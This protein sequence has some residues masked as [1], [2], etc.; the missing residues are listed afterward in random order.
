MA[1]PTTV[2]ALR[3]RDTALALI[4]RPGG[5]AT[6][7]RDIAAAAEVSPALL[8]RHYGS[9]DGVR[10]AVNAHVTATVTAALSELVSDDLLDAGAQ[11]SLAAAL[12]DRLG[13]DSPIPRY[14]LRML[15][16]GGD[17]GRA[18]F[19]ELYAAGRRTVDAMVRAGV[20]TDA[21]DPRA[22]AVVLTTHD[23]AVLILR[24]PIT[25]ALGADP[26]SPA[27]ATTWGTE[28]ADIYRGLQPPETS[29][30]TS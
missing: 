8:I 17:S 15:V 13:A 30:E 28:L 1:P 5:A 16:D 6:T 22:R 9:M 19:R 23:L 4:A 24:E 26:L 12:L 21:S 10:D 27:G 18:L 29:E 20:L 14:L 3:I 2:R 11:D 25:E 7:V